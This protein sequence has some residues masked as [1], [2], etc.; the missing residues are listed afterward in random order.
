MISISTPPP[1]TRSMLRK[2]PDKRPSVQELMA[3]AAL[4]DSMERARA[5]ALEVCPLLRLPPLLGP[6][7]PAPCG[8]EAGE[9][10]SG[11]DGASPRA[12][13]TDWTE[14]E[15]ASERGDPSRW[16]G[17]AKVSREAVARRTAAALLRGGATSPRSPDEGG[18]V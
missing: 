13:V 12:S 17:W 1:I 9:S 11:L 7:V 3:H 10:G 15:S 5:R 18:F 8:S 16:A 6:W 2:D 4:R 14:D